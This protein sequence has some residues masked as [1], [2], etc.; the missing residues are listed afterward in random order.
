[1]AIIS[2][3]PI[4][5]NQKNLGATLGLWTQNDP[6]VVGTCPGHG[7][8]PVAQNRISK[9]LGPYLDIYPQLEGGFGSM[10]AIL[11]MLGHKA[12]NGYYAH[13]KHGQK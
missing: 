6:Q 10:R 5:K 3:N 12:K 11:P 9:S 7:P 2:Q 4:F 1:M 8:Q 13:S